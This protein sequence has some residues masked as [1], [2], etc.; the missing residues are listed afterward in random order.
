V[1]LH[2]LQER[3]NQLLEALRESAVRVEQIRGALALCDELIAEAEGNG[4]DIQAPSTDER[5]DRE[6][7]D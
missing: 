2:R 1:E 7:V 6:P 4:R 3:R 5:E